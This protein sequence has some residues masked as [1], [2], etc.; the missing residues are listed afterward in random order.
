MLM[1]ILGVRHYFLSH[2]HFLLLPLQLYLLQYPHLHF[3]LS[4]FHFFRQLFP[5]LQFQSFQRQIHLYLKC[6]LHRR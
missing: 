1:S 3:L 2:L 4:V 6:L 5:L